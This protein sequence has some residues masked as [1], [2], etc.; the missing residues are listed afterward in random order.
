MKLSD[1][2]KELKERNVSYNVFMTNLRN[3][4]C[5]YDEEFT[6]V[7]MRNYISYFTFKQILENSFNWEGTPEGYE[8]WEDIY[9]GGTCISPCGEIFQDYAISVLSNKRDK[10]WTI[11]DSVLTTA[12]KLRL[13]KLLAKDLGYE[14][15]E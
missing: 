1:F 10:Y 7:H 3:D 14:M 15:E 5:L 6:E 8:F 12:R 9:D 13:F 2:K 11:G 4:K